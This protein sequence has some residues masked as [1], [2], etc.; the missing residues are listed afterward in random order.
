MYPT[1]KIGA[2]SKLDQSSFFLQLSEKRK[3]L[4]TLESLEI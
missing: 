1:L 4:G 2:D 3:S